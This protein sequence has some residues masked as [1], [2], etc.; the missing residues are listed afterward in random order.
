MKNS[1]GI[2]LYVFFL[3]ILNEVDAE[4]VHVEPTYPQFET[5]FSVTSIFVSWAHIF[6]TPC[7]NIAYYTKLKLLPQGS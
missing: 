3:Y 4:K 1:P 6:H 7:T 5:V 2:K